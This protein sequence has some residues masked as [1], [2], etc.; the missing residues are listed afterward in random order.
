MTG[1][2]HTCSSNFSSVSNIIL[3]GKISAY[4][5]LICLRLVCDQGCGQ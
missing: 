4:M 5:Y 2:V 1:V 3:V